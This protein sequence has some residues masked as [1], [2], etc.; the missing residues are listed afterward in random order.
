MSRPR[1]T[2][3]DPPL[4]P[5]VP[6]TRRAAAAT[7]QV[8]GLVAANLVWTRLVASAAGAEAVV[9]ARPPVGGTSLVSAILWHALLRGSLEEL[10]FRGALF[11]WLRGRF[12]GGAAIVGS[13][14]LFG[15][16]HAPLSQAGIAT[17]LGLQLGAIRLAFG[18]PLAIAAHVVS[19]AAQLLA[20]AHAGL[21]SDAAS[22][23]VLVAAALVAGSAVAGI[24]QRVRSPSG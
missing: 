23:L 5:P 20:L 17:L 7:L 19:N 2:L 24:A 18:L 15:A 22:P 8:L 14:L 11:G 3:H 4:A 12:G 9:D 10:V 6:G 13:A 21:L 16:L 1:P